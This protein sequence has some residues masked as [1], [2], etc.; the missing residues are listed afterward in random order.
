MDKQLLDIHETSMRI[1][2]EVGIKLH[3]PDVVELLRRR[4]V[5]TSGDVVFLGRDQVMEAVE[6]APARFTLHARNP[7][8]H[9]EIGGDR[10]YFGGGYGSPTIVLPDGTRRYAEFADY[11]DL[12]KLV[13]QSD[14]FFINGGIL[15][16]PFDLPAETCFPLMVYT[17][18]HHTDKCLLGMAGG[19]RDLRNIM[20][21]VGMAFGGLEVI[22]E[23]PVLLSL[24][25]TT[26]PLQ[27]DGTALATLKVSAEFGQPVIISP[28]P[29]AGSTG[30]I[31][32]A[33]NIALGNAEALAGIAVFQMMAPGTPVVYG[34]Q[35]TTADMKTGAVSIGS[36][37]FSLETAFS[38]RLAKMYGLP[39]RGGGAS[40]DAKE[41][42]AQ[43]GYEA[44]LALFSSCHEKVNLIL[45]SAG[46]LDAYGAMSYEQFFVDIE[47]IR[48]L[49]YYQRGI[50]TN[51]E[52]LAFEVIRDVGPAGQFLTHSHTLKHCRTAP[53]L[54]GINVRI[55]QTGR[56][57]HE[58]LMQNIQAKKTN[59][60]E[61]Y[62]KPDLDPAIAADLRRF[63][64]T[65][66][67]EA[68]LLD[69]AA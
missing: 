12:L 59:L 23:T 62:R 43:S 69:P 30:P 65:I 7:A 61:S 60:L 48:M 55:A 24:L 13:H 67:T 58:A 52:T 37:G 31:T 41:V 32:L 39:C 19:D 20:T 26:S 34:L 38:A 5:R 3:D 45:H 17:A 33:G 68:A 49:E 40:S 25:N 53:W 4:G 1:L 14:C 57:A 10:T 56:A 21:L 15:A 2:E 8:Y 28:G 29:I 66:G 9:M 22:R 51:E 35:A 42:S 64:E 36:P 27:I 6:N 47:I 44:S 11:R 16:Q 46:I 50:Q 18:L 63:M 54:Q